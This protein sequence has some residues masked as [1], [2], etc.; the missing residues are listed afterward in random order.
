ME[1]GF[2]QAIRDS[3]AALDTWL[4]LA[5]WLEE[6]RQ[7]DR[8]ELVRLS[9]QLRQEL[10]RRARVPL[11]RRAR[12]LARAG[13]Q[14]CVPTLT[15]SLGLRLALVPPGSFWMGSPHRRG[16]SDDDEFPCHRV[17]ITRPLYLG[18][19]Q[20]TQAQ[21]EQVMGT[22]PSYFGPGGEGGPQVRHLD[23]R[24][25][26][27][28]S[29][30]YRDVVAFCRRLSVLPEEKKA[31]RVYRLPSEAEWEYACRAG[32]GHTA[33][34]F[35]SRLTGREARFGSAGG[36]HPLPVGSFPPN[37]FGLYDLHGN[38]WEW[39][40][41]WYDNRYYERSPSLDPPGPADGQRRVLRGGGWGT[42]ATWCRSALRGH[43][44]PDARYNYN[45]VRVAVSCLE[46]RRGGAVIARANGPGTGGVT[47]AS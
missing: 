20:V 14:P 8:A 21:Y 7:A 38:V 16:A 25:L 40:A 12:A 32:I 37:L 27:V 28:E 39:C 2:L 9:V 4:V 45:G 29:V 35:G 3:P 46:P 6:Q 18:V 47:R 42:P 23:A 31:G 41:D 30:S 15:N 5:D 13:A 17:T 34:H 44:T 10:D 24:R 26:P 1:A 33:Y 36:G 11:E 19:T 22:N 43:N